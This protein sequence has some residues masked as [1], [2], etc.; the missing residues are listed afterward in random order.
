MTRRQRQAKHAAEHRHMR[1]RLLRL[2]GAANG[3]VLEAGRLWY[4]VAEGIVADMSRE[5][6]LGRPSVAAIIA[7]LSPQQRWRKNVA[8]ARAVLEG[9]PWAAPGYAA[10]REKAERLCEG[11][12]PL[13]VLGG[14]KVTNFWANLN[15]SREAVTVDRWAQHAALGFFYQHQPKDGRY[16][17]LARA[18]RAAAKMVGETPREFQA[19]VWLALRPAIE[20][21]RDWRLIHAAAAR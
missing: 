7:V 3:N 2:Y 8:G 11:E 4:P 5:F 15:G 17:R 16:A 18:Y 10:N 20:H 1:D 6:G 21:E 14:D 19:C 12:S 9:R 13:T